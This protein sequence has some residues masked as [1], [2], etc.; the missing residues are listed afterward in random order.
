MVTFLLLFTIITFVLIDSIHAASDRSDKVGSALTS[1][2][3]NFVNS[4]SGWV[5]CNEGQWANTFNFKSESNQGKTGD[6]TA[7]NGVRLICERP[8]SSTE[9]PYET[10]S[11][12]KWGNWYATN[13]DSCPQGTWLNGFRTNVEGNQGFWVDDTALNCVEMKCSD[14]TT[15][16]PTHCNTWGSWQSTY[17]YCSSG[18][19]CGFQEKYETSGF[20]D[21]ETGLNAVQ[22]RCC[23]FTDAPTPSPTPSPSPSP[24][25]RPTDGP[26]PS[27]TDNPTPSPTES[28]TESPTDNPTPSPTARPTD[29]PT[30]SPSISP[31]SAPTDSTI[32]PISSPTTPITIQTNDQNNQGSFI[33]HNNQTDWTPLYV[34]LGIVFGLIC[35]CLCIG[36]IL[37]YLWYKQK[38]ETDHVNAQPIQQA[39]PIS[40]DNDNDYDI[41]IARAVAKEGG[42]NTTNITT[43]T[44]GNNNYETKIDN[45][46]NLLPNDY[47]DDELDSDSDNNENDALYAVKKKKSAGGYHD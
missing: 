15:L 41:E 5:Y 8:G 9:Y 33:V 11:E 26:T 43:I 25:T 36:G 16:T 14:G 17:T 24:T 37:A 31:T 4:W 6:D 30:P 23:S 44:E 3:A 46:E 38:K 7:G 47:N 45:E 13:P 32:S 19:I 22:F 10:G 42:D 1:S 2:E 20:A 18:Y 35:C 29:G 34:A 27:P 40:D 28:P 21:D 39:S 12:K